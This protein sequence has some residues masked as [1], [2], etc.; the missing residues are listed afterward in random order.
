MTLF[1]LAFF[2]MY[3]TAHAYFYLKTRSAF[4]LERWARVGLVLFLVLMVA[5][6]VLI[7]VAE[8]KGLEEVSLVLGYAGYLWMALLFFFFT[9]SLGLDILRFLARSIGASAKPKFARLVPSG[10]TAYAMAAAYAIVASVYGYFEARNIHVE[11]L[12]IHSPKIPQSIGSLRIAQISDVHLGLFIDR[13]RLRRIVTTVR[14]LDPDIV[15]S[16]GDL[17]DG[18]AGSLQGLA[19]ELLPLRPR[20]GMFAVTGNHEYYVGHDNSVAF[21]REA[22]FTLLEGEHLTVAGAIELA[23]VD[24]M[25]GARM[26]LPAKDEHALL[27]S[28][29]RDRFVLFLKHRPVVPATSAGLFDLQLSGH[30]HG[31][32]LFPFFL[33]TRLVFPVWNGL[34]TLPKGSRL[35]LSRG[36]GTWG[37]PLR[38]LAPPEV[39]LIELVHGS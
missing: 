34:T 5:A 37:P 8:R 22:G 12:V 2:L 39:T 7:R 32:Q 6:P 38:F 21:H 19:S 16:T 10:R 24:D 30:L 1:L 18:Q 26:G 36:T 17:V 20:Y 11:R 3:G 27:A 14:G 25:V 13:E 9:L 23:G 28:L 31:G 29:P 35:Y 15:V 33:L 4:R